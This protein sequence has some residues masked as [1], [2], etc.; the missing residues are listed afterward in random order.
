MRLSNPINYFRRNPLPVPQKVAEKFQALAFA[1]RGNEETLDGKPEVAMREA[2]RALGGG[3]LGY[4]LEHVG[5]IIHRMTYQVT[6]PEQ[7]SMGY[8]AVNKKVTSALRDLR[9]SYGFAREVSDNARINAQFLKLTPEEYE[10]RVGP[11]LKRYSQAHASLPVYNRAQWLAR[12]AAVSLGRRDFART[13]LAL[14]GLEPLLVD[15]ET[16]VANASE[17]RLDSD[18]YPILYLH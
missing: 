11:R 14:E 3:M 6:W 10:A 16:W 2:V 7:F 8:D 13:L 5:D 17:Y 9:R 15:E 4:H 18:G 1:Q 12:E